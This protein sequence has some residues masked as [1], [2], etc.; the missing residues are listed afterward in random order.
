MP[1]LAGLWGLFYGKM[2]VCMIRS[3]SP[4][5]FLRPVFATVLI[6]WQLW[7]ASFSFGEE[8]SPRLFRIGT[9]GTTG[10]YYPIGIIIAHGL[11]GWQSDE[12]SGVA[13]YIGVAQ[14]SAGS[15]ENVHGVT[16]GELE[17]GLVQA[18]IAAWA[19]NG[20]HVFA[21]DNS[22]RALRAVAS[23]YPEKFQIVTR[24]D[25]PRLTRSGIGSAPDSQKMP[26]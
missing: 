2:M 17:A 20:K 9:G 14:N 4:R 12:Q 1:P 19:F 10:V 24:P 25:D 13:G 6:L 23:L 11:T 26:R 21:G 7:T 22:A 16:S 8:N 15:V 3:L 5:R 18:D